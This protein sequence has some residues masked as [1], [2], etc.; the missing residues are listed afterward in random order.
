MVVGE[1]ARKRGGRGFFRNN[2]L[3]QGTVEARII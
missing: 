3:K 2:A 1:E